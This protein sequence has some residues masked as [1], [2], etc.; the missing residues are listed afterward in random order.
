MSSG[1]TPAAHLA[2]L[3]QGEEEEFFVKRE[4]EGAKNEVF[5]N[6]RISTKREEEAMSV[7]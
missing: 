1:N 2:T 7:L 5:L 4:R 6:L 3:S